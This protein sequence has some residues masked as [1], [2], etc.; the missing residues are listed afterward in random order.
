MIEY[1]SFKRNIVEGKKDVCMT[2][3][4][5]YQKCLYDRVTTSVRTLGGNTKDFPIR[6]GLH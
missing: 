5:I 1:L 2:Y 3:I 6:I 4:R